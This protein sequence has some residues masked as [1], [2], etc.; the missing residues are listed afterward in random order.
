MALTVAELKA[1]L[2][3]F[4][5]KFDDTFPV[6]YHTSGDVEFYISGVE[7]NSDVGERED[8]LITVEDE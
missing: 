4:D 8:V 1:E 7:L 2:A 5:A 6:V 3:K